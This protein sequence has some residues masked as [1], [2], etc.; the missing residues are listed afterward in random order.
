MKKIKYILLSIVSIGLF[1]CGDDSYSIAYE[2]TEVKVPL[3]GSI[4]LNRT[5]AAP[6]TMVSFDYTIPQSFTS[7][8]II[9]VTS[10]SSYS[11]LEF[12]AFTSKSYITVPAGQTSG[13]GM[14]EMGGDASDV[15]DDF[16]G[17]PNYATA[18]ISGIALVQPEDGPKIDDPY[19]MTSEAVSITGLDVHDPFM[20]PNLDD[21]DEPTQTLMISLDWEGPWNI[22]DLD[23]YVYNNDGTFESAEAGGRYEGDFFNNPANE[24]HPDGDYIIEFVLYDPAGAVTAPVAWRLNLTHPDG[25]V[26][27]YEG[28]IDPAIGYIDPVGFTQVTDGSGVRTFTTYAL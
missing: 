13:T 6:G 5:S 16:Y 27:V 10:S 19:T 8:A 24:D 2:D 14:F 28:T 15:F 17:V 22:N 21:D 20:F 11:T 3:A 18:S 26:D 4:L 7:D 25:S 12:N 9:E 23:M 1:S